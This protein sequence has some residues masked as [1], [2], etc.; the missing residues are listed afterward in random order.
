MMLLISPED[1][2]RLSQA[3][4]QELLSL[5]A[6]RSGSISGDEGYAYFGEDEDAV[7]DK[8]QQQSGRQTIEDVLEEK[9]VI[10]INVE[11]ARDLVANISPES[12][13]T[14][15]LFARGTP[16]AL[17]DLIGDGRP[18]KDFTY[19]KRSFVG[20]VNR[21]LRTVSGNRLAVLFSSDR[22]KTRIRITSAAAASLR[23]V[24]DVPEP[25]PELEFFDESG[26]STSKD[27]AAANALQHRLKLAWQGFK[28]RPGEGRPSIGLIDVV[29]HLTGNGFQA[30]FGAQT[31]WDEESSSPMYAFGPIESQEQAVARLTKRFSN[32]DPDHFDHV[33]T[34][35]VFL[36]H[37]EAPGILATMDLLVI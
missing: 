37:G 23:Q 28:G 22:D 36:S 32:A 27:S 13:Q 34:D 25:L 11:Q 10:D 26:K 31:T 19:L 29:K 33:D 30:R 20:A 14:L 18:Y 9:R 1:F 6:P 4:R 15:R 17:D 16:V 3:C 21:R 24:L 35:H 5:L 8:D 2:Q 12:Q 7:A